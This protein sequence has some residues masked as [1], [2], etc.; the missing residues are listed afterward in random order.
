[1]TPKVALASSDEMGARAWV[2]IVRMPGLC[3]SQLN[4]LPEV[5]SDTVQTVIGSL[6][7]DILYRAPIF[8]ELE[9]NGS[10]RV[11]VGSHSGQR[12]TSASTDHTCSGEAAIVTVD[13]NCFICVLRVSVVKLHIPVAAEFFKSAFAFLVLRATRT[14][15]H[16]GVAQFR[17]NFRNCFGV[18]LDR[19]RAGLA[20]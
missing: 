7:C 17:D 12:T 11:T 10:T 15:G 1:M 18:G 9:S 6:G 2:A 19:K 3:A 8:N 5:N 13:S 4:E 14:F 16:F 20:A